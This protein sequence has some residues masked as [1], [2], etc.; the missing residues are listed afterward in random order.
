MTQY[1]I[2]KH[3]LESFTVLPGFIWRTDILPPKMPIGF[4][5]INE[6]DRWIE[7]AYIKDEREREPCSLIKGFRECTREKWYDDVP[8][9]AWHGKGWMIKGK[10]YGDQPRHPVTVPPINELL[11]YKVVGPRTII[12]IEREEFVHIRKETFRRYLDP[13]EIPLLAQSPSTNRRFYPL[14]SRDTRN[15]GSRKSSGSELASRICSSRST[16][17]KFT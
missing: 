1:F 16:A 11:G 17:R 8:P 3:D 15:S 9:H 13:R 4:R 7:F 6:G 10:K 2:V 14:S 5:Q 12:R